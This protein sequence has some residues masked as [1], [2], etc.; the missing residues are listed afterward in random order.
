MS[1]LKKS[2]IIGEIVSFVWV[3]MQKTEFH[4]WQ[5]YRDKK[6]AVLDVKGI[7][8]NMQILKLSTATHSELDV[9]P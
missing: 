5:E 1:E 2:K 9:W 8:M 4:Y 7:F 6:T 3:Y